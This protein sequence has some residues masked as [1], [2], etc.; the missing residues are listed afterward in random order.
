[1]YNQNS[2]KTPGGGRNLI[3]PSDSLYIVREKGISDEIG[4]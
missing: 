1:M 3:D 2:K 4:G